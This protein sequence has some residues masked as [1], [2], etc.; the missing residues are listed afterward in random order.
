M[1]L[2]SPWSRFV[3]KWDGRENARVSRKSFEI[4][5]FFFFF[6]W[7]FSFSCFL[8]IFAALLSLWATGPTSTVAA[9]HHPRTVKQPF[10]HGTALV[11]SKKGG[12]HPCPRSHSSSS[13]YND[14][15]FPLFSSSSSV[16]A[17][18]DI[19]KYPSFWSVTTTTPTVIKKNHSWVTSSST[20]LGNHH[21]S[22][23]FAF[24]CQHGR[25]VLQT[26]GQ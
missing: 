17:G 18:L 23:S 26:A 9:F 1:S 15:Y 11:S 25:Y 2:T 14:Y 3:C 22:G 7:F 21:E 8:C 6:S 10:R 13:F 19:L 16:Q 24:C 20:S 12:I 5:T 4:I